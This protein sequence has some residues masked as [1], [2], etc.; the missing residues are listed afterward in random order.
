[1]TFYCKY[2]SC[3]DLFGNDLF[4]NILCEQLSEK[5]EILTVVLSLLNSNDVSI[6]EKQARH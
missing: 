6:H 2:S 1:M 5:P 4:G 3:N